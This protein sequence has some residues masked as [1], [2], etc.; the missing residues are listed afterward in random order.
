[1]NLDENDFSNV[2][3]AG[4]EVSENSQIFA[5]PLGWWGEGGIKK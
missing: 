3:R 4:G 1:M 5:N 2:A